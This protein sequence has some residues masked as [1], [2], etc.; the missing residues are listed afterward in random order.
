M[1]GSDVNVAIVFFGV[2]AVEGVLGVLPSLHIVVVIVCW[3]KVGVAEVAIIFMQ[4]LFFMTKMTCP[5]TFLA[6]MATTRSEKK[7]K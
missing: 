7:S 6:K 2:S 1:V 4:N 5:P 3:L